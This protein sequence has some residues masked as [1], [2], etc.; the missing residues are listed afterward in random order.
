MARK[1]FSWT[2]KATKVLADAGIG[3]AEKIKALLDAS[4]AEATSKKSERKAEFQAWYEA[5]KAQLATLAE[6]INTI[7]TKDGR[8]VSV[9]VTADGEGNVTVTPS[10]G[11]DTDEE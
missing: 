7:A 6:G 10:F 2:E 1:G 8:S 3:D 11:R 4:K 9:T 5:N